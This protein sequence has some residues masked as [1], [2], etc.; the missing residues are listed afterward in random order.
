MQL[1]VLGCRSGMPADGQPSAGYLVQTPGTSMLLDCGP[2][3]LAALTAVTPVRRLDAVVI[4]HLHTDHCYDLLPL[5]K[6]L[7]T[8]L[9]RMAGGPAADGPPFRPVPLFV[10]TGVG[11]LLTRWAGLFPVTTMPVLNRPFELAFDVVEYRAGDRYTVGDC[12]LE[13]HELRHV[14]PNCGAR[15][16]SASGVLA[17][18]GDTGVCS[19]LTDLAKDADV[20]L[21]EATLSAPDVTEHG[22]LS[23]GCAGRAAEE[24]EVGELVLTHF[25]STE[26]AWL[27][28]LLADARAGFRGPVSLAAPGRVIPVSRRG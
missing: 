3:I 25:A 17:Y 16:E 2:G 18:T 28:A 8:G 15:V 7:L 12:S 20:L 10:P 6:A 21:A 13:L 4:S 14:A 1:T 9:A 27:A 11:E 26:P 22:H 5:G 19:G 23:G 24:A